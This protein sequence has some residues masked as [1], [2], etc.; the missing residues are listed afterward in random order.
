[1]IDLAINFIEHVLLPLGGWGVFF[2]SVIEEVIAPIPSA[3]VITLSGFLFLK[4][5]FSLALILKLFF[6]V[7]LPASIGITVGSLFIYGIAY[8]FGK[9]ALEKWG[10]WMGLSWADIEKLQKKFDTRKVDELALFSLRAI[11]I[12]PSVA[13]SAW[14]GIVRFGLK[15]YILFTILGTFV[16]AIILALVGWQVGAF[17]YTYAKTIASIEKDIFIIIVICVLFFIGYKIYKRKTM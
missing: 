15:K 2:A 4:G 16:R 7:A 14:Y 1:M 17:Y 13:I 10:K 3:L 5:S 11:P 6:V 8:Y 12:I 9:P